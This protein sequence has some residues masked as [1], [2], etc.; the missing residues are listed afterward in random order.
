MVNPIS[1]V[2]LFG[3]IAVT[4]HSKP[5]EQSASNINDDKFWNEKLL[6]ALSKHDYGNNRLI[7][8][9][10]L[11][12]SRV[13]QSKDDQTLASLL[14][15]LNSYY[16]PEE[17]FRDEQQQQQNDGKTS[18]SASELLQALQSMVDYGDAN[19]GSASDLY[20]QEIGSNPD[21]G[22]YYSDS[23]MDQVGWFMNEPV[24]PKVRPI[25]NDDD[26]NQEGQTITNDELEKMIL[27]YFKD[28][29]QGQSD[30]PLPLDGMV[31]KRRQKI[32]IKDDDLVSLTPKPIVPLAATTTTASPSRLF[33]RK[34]FENVRG[35]QKEVALLRPAE[36]K[37]KEWPSELEESVPVGIT[38]FYININ[39]GCF[40][41]S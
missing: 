31:Q 12:Q 15:D 17:R 34:Q 21:S 13:E 40:R 38:L 25:I 33:L 28:R 29:L 2:L 37:S 18:I 9:Q 27:H 32:V 6:R 41:N 14:E 22:F 16:L 4:V 39:F 3:I 20:Q 8:P 1:L 36:T 35:G 10:T 23:P 5:L 11:T 26:T 24:V 30:E 7:L 19:T